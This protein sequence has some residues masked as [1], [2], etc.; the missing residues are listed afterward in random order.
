M[1]SL[2]ATLMCFGGCFFIFLF[3]PMSSTPFWKRLIC[4]CCLEVKG[5]ALGE[6]SSLWLAK[7]RNS[8]KCPF[9]P[10]NKLLGNADRYLDSRR[11]NPLPMQ[12][13][14]LRLQFSSL[15]RRWMFFIIRLSK[16]SKEGLVFSSSEV[17]LLPC[18]P[19][20]R[21]SV[22]SAERRCSFPPRWALQTLWS[23][24]SSP[25]RWAGPGSAL[26]THT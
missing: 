7:H 16:P 20:G 25:Q 12:K 17:F 8:N 23:P 5:W 13:P 26:S 6:C 11:K 2:C 4:Y 10:G 19:L 22:G 21:R 15:Q 24:R 9:F 3:K 14:I 18:L 1:L